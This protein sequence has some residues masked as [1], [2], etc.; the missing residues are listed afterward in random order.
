M[1]ITDLQVEVME[2]LVHG[3]FLLHGCSVANVQVALLVLQLSD[4]SLQSTQVSPHAF[5]FSL[6]A[7]GLVFQ[8]HH[9][10]DL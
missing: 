1:S 2:A 4:V 5:V 6:K 9:L 8:V 10:S 7:P 3:G